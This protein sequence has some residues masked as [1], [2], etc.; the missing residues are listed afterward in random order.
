MTIAASILQENEAQI[1]DICQMGSISRGSLPILHTTPISLM[2][3]LV[4]AIL[5]LKQR[6]IIE[7]TYRVFSNLCCGY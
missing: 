6:R 2:K 1:L 7:L 4:S 5:V 3:P